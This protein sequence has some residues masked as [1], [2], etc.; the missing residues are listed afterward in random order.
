MEQ[1]LGDGVK[2]V[3]DLVAGARVKLCRSLVS[4]QPIVAGTVLDE[5]MVCLKSPGG[6]L[7]WRE[8]DQVMGKKAQRDIPADVTLELKD[9]A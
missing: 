8:R 6:G 5:S 1:A 7:L 4:R 3:T 2:R 9:F